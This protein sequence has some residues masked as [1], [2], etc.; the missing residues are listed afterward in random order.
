VAGVHALEAGIAGFAQSF[1][2]RR[3]G[4]GG[5]PKFPRPSELLFLLH[6]FALTG[7]WKARTMAVDTLRA[8]S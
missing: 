4:F 1:D 8:M 6:A 3:G 5:A 7:D 2:T